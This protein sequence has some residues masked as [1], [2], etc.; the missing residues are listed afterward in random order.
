MLI[1]YY[2]PIVPISFIKYY[3]LYILLF[4]RYVYTNYLV[5]PNIG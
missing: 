1:S 3:L 2:V 4:H 5:E